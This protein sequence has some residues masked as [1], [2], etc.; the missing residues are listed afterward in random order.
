M[1][2]QQWKVIA[3]DAGITIGAASTYLARAISYV[4]SGDFP[5][6][7]VAWRAHLAAASSELTDVQR[8]AVA[9]SSG[10]DGC[11]KTP[12]GCNYRAPLHSVNVSIVSTTTIPSA[13]QA[14]RALRE[15]RGLAAADVARE[16]GVSRQR[17][18][19]VEALPRVTPYQVDRYRR[20][21]SRADDARLQRIADTL[22]RGGG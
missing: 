3:G 15:A 20:A 11:M 22:R 4:G 1:A 21:V 9:W 16:A 2:G 10:A 7:A 18:T 12:A 17:I 19:V 8:L 13:G 14:L 6:A 5:S